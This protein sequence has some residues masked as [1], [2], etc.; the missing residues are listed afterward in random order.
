MI[1][2]M[3]QP[4]RLSVVPQRDINLALNIDPTAA[5]PPDMA[6]KMAVYAIGISRVELVHAGAELRCKNTHIPHACMHVVQIRICSDFLF[7]LNCI[8]LIYFI[9]NIFKY[10]FYM[11]KFLD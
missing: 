6:G 8:Q 10:M 7:M 1:R 5:A 4:M 3:R 2:R 11:I 9:K